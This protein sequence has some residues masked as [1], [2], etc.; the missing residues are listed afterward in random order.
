MDNNIV[1]QYGDVVVY[2][3]FNS[4]ENKKRSKGVKPLTP[5]EVLSN[6]YRVVKKIEWLEV[7]I[8]QLE[9]DI[10]ELTAQIEEERRVGLEL[11]ASR[12]LVAAS[13]G[14]PIHKLPKG[15][16]D[17]YII[18]EAQINRLE[19]ELIQKR[20]ILLHKEQ[21]IRELREE[22]ESTRRIISEL[23]SDEQEIA[24]MIYRDRL[25]NCHI[26]IELSYNEKTIRRKKEQIIQKI[27]DKCREI[28][29][30]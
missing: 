1:W 24:E 3:S 12:K 21:Q 20:T 22:T 4:L 19:K 27:I 25:S 28:A 10:A 13:G 16:D 23:E 18:Y 9:T 11:V 6:Y 8:Q 26:A 5:E 17:A 30:K 15:L 29:E 14:R 7:D 2:D